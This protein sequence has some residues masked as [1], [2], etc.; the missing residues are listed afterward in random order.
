M[1]KAHNALPDSAL[2]GDP[3]MRHRVGRE[4]CKWCRMR[5]PG[6]IVLSGGI[7]M[8]MPRC[9]WMVLEVESQ[10]GEQTS[11][12]FGFSYNELRETGDPCRFLARKLLTALGLLEA[13]AKGGGA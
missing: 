9:I 6:D 13:Q 4:I 5:L 11:V 3:G 8:P 12:D 10:E 7:A 2:L 1:R